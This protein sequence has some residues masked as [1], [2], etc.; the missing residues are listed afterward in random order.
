MSDAFTNSKEIQAA[1]AEYD[2]KAIL[3]NVVIGCMLGIVLMPVGTLLDYYVYRPEVFYFF[4]LRLFCSLLI[5]LFWMVVITPFGRQHPRKLGV[6]L[7]FFPAFFISWMI[8]ATDG[9]SSP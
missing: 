3:S 4:K 1:F 7:A 8:Y 6:L 2:R 9:E 5:G